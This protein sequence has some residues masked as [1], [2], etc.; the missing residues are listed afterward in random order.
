[1]NDNEIVILNGKQL[2]LAEFEQAK[3]DL[4]NQNGLQLFESA[5]G[6]WLTRLFD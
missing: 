1:M 2:T 5:P 6:V 3:K 4:L